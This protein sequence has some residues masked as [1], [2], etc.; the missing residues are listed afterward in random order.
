MLKIYYNPI[1]VCEKHIEKSF[2]KSPLKPKLVLEG[3]KSKLKED[4]YEVVDYTPYSKED[5]KLAHYDAHIN[6]VYEFNQEGELMENDLPWSK[7]LV[8]SLEY[9][10]A[11]IYN[12]IKNSILD[13][14]HIYASLTSGYHHSRPHMGIGFCTFSGQVIASLK[15]YEEFGAIGAYID[16]DS[17]FG[18]SIEDTKVF[19][20]KVNEC[21]PEWANFNPRQSH[22]NQAYINELG[23][24]LYTFLEQKILD[25]QC[26]YIVY[27]HGADSIEGDASGGGKVTLE[28][29]HYCTTIFWTWYNQL[30]EKLGRKFPVSL[31]LFGG[32]RD[33]DFQ[34]VIDAHVNDILMGLELK[35]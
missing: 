6:G 28:Q 31:S 13:P 1:Q 10:N 22:F 33:D 9:T 17:H 4:Q 34:Y 30:C 15:V 11:S 19:N 3:L 7:E 27:C 24:Y 2:S 29:W 14:E 18:N 5:F 12:T 8:S 26:Q 21:I 25:G 16:L 23:S 32:Y 35:K 20:P